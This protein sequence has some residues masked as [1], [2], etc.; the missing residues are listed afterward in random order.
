MVKE[1]KEKNEQMGPHRKAM[2]YFDAHHITMG[3]KKLKQLYFHPAHVFPS[4][5]PPS[6]LLRI[7]PGN[8]DAINVRDQHEILCDVQVA[9]T[10][11][12]L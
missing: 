12:S 10:L 4:L 9:W 1:N 6:H 5:Q 8:H 2:V 11:Q 7:L 3:E